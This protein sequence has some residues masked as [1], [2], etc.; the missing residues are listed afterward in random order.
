MA[1]GANGRRKAGRF[2]FRASAL[3]DR[4]VGSFG[5]SLLLRRPRAPVCL[6]A[7]DRTSTS[8]SAPLPVPWGPEQKRL[9]A[10]ARRDDDREALEDLVRQ[11]LPLARR[12]ARKY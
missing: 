1:G 2:A 4:Q 9:L 8:S 11:M 12:L 7:M 3:G 6:K 10:R 5:P